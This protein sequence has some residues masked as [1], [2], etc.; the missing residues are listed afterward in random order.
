MTRKNITIGL[1]TVLGIVLSIVIF[2]GCA[3]LLGTAKPNPK[4]AAQ[5][6]EKG[7][8]LEKQGDLPSALEQYKL[9]LTADPQNEAAMQNN[10]RLT[11]ELSKL[12][13]ARYDLG[14]KYHRQGKYALARKQF[15]TALKYQPD[16]P[17]ASRMLVSR[18]PEKAPEYVLHEVQKGESLSMIAQKYYGDYKKYDVIADY[19]DLKDATMV[20]PGQTIRIPNITGSL[21]TLPATKMKLEGSDFVV[22]TIEPGQSI[23]RLAQIYYGDYHKFHIIAQF[24]KMDDATQVKVGDKVKIPK[25]DGLPFNLPSQ[26]RPQK[27]QMPVQ[28]GAEAKAMAPP[29]PMPA[30]G[31]PK[32]ALDVPETLQPE[33][34]EKTSSEN[35]LQILAYRDA[36]IELYNEGK[37]EDAI[38]ELNKSV[39]ALPDDQQTRTYLAKAYFESGKTQLNQKEYD[40]AKEAFE[41]ALQFDPNCAECKSYIEKS[42][43]GPLLTYRSKGIDHFNRNQFG[44]AISVLHQYLQVVPSDAEAR[45]YLGKAYFQK[46]LI[47]YNKADFMTAKN[48]FESALEYDSQC[49]KC[50][51]Y[52]NQ[53]LESHKETHYSKGVAYYGRQQL[54]EAVKEWELV[55]ELDPDYKDVDQNLKKAR[56]LMKKLEQIKK[57]QQQ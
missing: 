41:S 7:R 9:A 13:D 25:V 38:F 52:I 3:T 46:A 55:Y 30:S 27:P 15:L 10:E 21:Q 50:A 34:P 56:A 36:G 26:E 5:Y 43:S 28:A 12:A 53:S 54:G 29:S 22:H 23:S 49:E 51:T 32:S 11:K 31:P 39:E 14:M 24:N 57:S 6:L 8:E 48:G 1:L 35:N 19:N 42:K 20:K 47:D 4:L 44:D 2:S 18:Q 33:A 16:H 37:Y 40:S 17:G 45:I